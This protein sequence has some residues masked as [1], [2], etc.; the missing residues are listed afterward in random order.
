MKT[1]TS[2]PAMAKALTVLFL[3]ATV[4]A[5]T[6]ATADAAPMS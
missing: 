4:L 3:A 2:R 5:G 6:A 1:V